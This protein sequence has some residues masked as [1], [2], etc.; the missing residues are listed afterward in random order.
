MKHAMSSIGVFGLV[1]LA[2]TSNALAATGS[3]AS[4][5]PPSAVAPRTIEDLAARL[6]GGNEGGEGGGG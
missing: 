1:L 2:V 6:G 5:F 4:S 3:G